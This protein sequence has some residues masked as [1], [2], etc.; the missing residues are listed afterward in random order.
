MQGIYKIRNKLDDKRYVGSSNNFEGHWKSYRDSLRKGKF[1][2]I[3]LQRAWN[4][5]GE[6]NFI[7]EIEEEVMG[8]RN[9]L[10]S[11]EQAHLDEGF[12]LGIL[13]N[14]AE[15]AGCPPSWEGEHHTEAAK[16]KIGKANS[17]KNN[18]M[19]GRV[20]YWKGKQR[21]EETKVRMSKARMGREPWNKGKPRTEV[22]KAKLRE[23]SKGNENKAEPYPAFYNSKTGI[24]IPEGKNLRKM[25]RDCGLHYQNVWNLKRLFVK[26]SRDGWRLAT[27]SEIANMAGAGG[28]A[29]F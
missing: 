24:F 4:K 15:K 2:N 20:G 25:C 1:H 5:Y 27:E 19:Y 21:S 11:F 18:G 12:E 6:E 16:A 8:D 10:L 28:G 3:Y 13:Y 14:L 29:M 26:Q 23:A 22:V 9:V 17:G 7:F